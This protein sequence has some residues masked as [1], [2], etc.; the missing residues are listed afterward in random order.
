MKKQKQLNTTY[1]GISRLENCVL[2]LMN[3]PGRMRVFGAD[4]LKKVSDLGK[5][6]ISNTLFTLHRK[7][8]LVR[9]ERNKYAVRDNIPGNEFEIATGLMAP[10]Y[11]SFWSAL[12]FYG[13]T[14]QQVFA[15]QLVSTRQH[16]PML[17]LDRR[18]EVTKF[19]P[20]RFYGY[21]RLGAFSIATKEKSIIDSLSDFRKAGGAHEF[22]KCL[23]TAWDELDKKTLVDS[24]LRFGNRSMNSRFGF[25]TDALGL[26]M[27]TQ[28]KKKM[29]KNIPRGFVKLE[30]SRKSSAHY[31]K[32][33][34]INVND[35]GAV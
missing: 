12:S 17:L 30:P 34:K 19:N 20:K 26:K 35:G 16:K 18:I 4:E 2:S 23:E 11:V 9:L 15:I 24:L 27:D 14:E 31:D 21:A 22:A 10:S 25:L 7:G 28:L 1:K 33:W 3:E 5:I 13:F 29:Q 32:K 8:L 6:Q